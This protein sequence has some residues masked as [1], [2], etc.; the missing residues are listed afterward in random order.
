MD[1]LNYIQYVLPENA[2]TVQVILKDDTVWCTQKAMAQLFGIGIPAVSKHLKNVF[3]EGELDPATTISKMETLVQRG[4]RGEV[5]E[6][7]VFY[8]LDAIIAVGYRVSSMKAT[9]FR[10]WATSVL[11]S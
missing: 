5:P 7:I 6:S 1:E 10:Q 11:N 9:R 8:N 3:Y 4:F 2:G